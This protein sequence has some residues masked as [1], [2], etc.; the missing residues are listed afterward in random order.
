MTYNVVRADLGGRKA[1]ARAG[2]EGTGADE[3]VAEAGDAGVGADAAG[4][5]AGISG[6]G[7]VTG[8]ICWLSWG[9][10]CGWLLVVLVLIFVELQLCAG[11]KWNL[12]CL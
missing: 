7:T 6:A 1:V 12:V 8:G 5:C 11:L 4:A 2:A 9:G 10:S 3:G